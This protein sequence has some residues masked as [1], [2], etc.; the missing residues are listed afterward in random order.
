VTSADMPNSAGEPRLGLFHRF[1]DRLFPLIR[2]WHERVKG[3]EWFSQITPQLWLGGA[4][5]TAADY[6]RL[7]ACG[8][9][10]VVDVRAER[11]D[12]SAFYQRHGIAYARYR[13]PDVT[14]PDAAT[15]GAAVDWIRDRVD[16]GR[17]VLVHCAKGRG[18]SATLLAGYLMRE[19]GHDYDAAR[20]LLET[21]RRL[22]KLEPRHRAVLEAWLAAQEPPAP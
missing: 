6:A 4:P 22:T 11:Q 17:V 3:N 18:R 19:R 13:V 2:F 8:I 5:V 16:E 21:K 1:F 7:V 15:I 10:A 12:D 20:E 14:V 9:T